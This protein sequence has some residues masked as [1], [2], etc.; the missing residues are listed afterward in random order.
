MSL[1]D[2][3]GRLRRRPLVQALF[4]GLGGELVVTGLGAPSWDL[5]AR[6]DRDRTFYLWGAMGLAVPTGLGLAL[7][8]PGERVIVVTGDGEVMMGLGSLA[9]VAAAAPRNLAV[10]VLDNGEF[11]ETGGQR[12]LSA[13]GVDIAAVARAAGFAE[14]LTVAGE[15][16]VD[17]LRRL[18][19]ERPGPVLAVARIAPGE[20]AKVLPPK[21]G[22]V[23]RR[24]FRADLGLEQG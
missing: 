19:F 5:A 7:A 1:L 12:G 20:D 22:V 3:H 17:D 2:N 8:R 13:R 23:L 6:G 24:R 16:A 10:L 9:T 14:T 21:D 11:G 15:D 18:L 4:A